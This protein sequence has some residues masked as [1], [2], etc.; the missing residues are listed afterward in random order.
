MPTQRKTVRMARTYTITEQ[1]VAIRLYQLL[2][3][4]KKKTH[5]I[6]IITHFTTFLRFH[7]KP[8]RIDKTQ[9]KPLYKRRYTKRAHKDCMQDID[10]IT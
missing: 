1:L 9:A 6:I 2:Y 8:G 10:K 4:R 5:I 3:K 7:Y